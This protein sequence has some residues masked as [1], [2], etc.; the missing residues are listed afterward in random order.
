MQ[1][2]L[3]PIDE[4]FVEATLAGDVE[5][6]SRLMDASIEFYEFSQ[7]ETMELK[8][9]YGDDFERLFCTKLVYQ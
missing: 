6:A 3:E 8:M 1:E 9:L 7:A 2:N 4:M 5:R